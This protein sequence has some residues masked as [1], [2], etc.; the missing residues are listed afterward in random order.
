MS[1]Y[2]PSRV[3]WL[4]LCTALTACSQPAN[5]VL[6]SLE[7]PVAALTWCAVPP[8]APRPALPFAPAATCDADAASPGHALAFVLDAAT[9]ELRAADLTAGDPLDLD[10]FRPSFNGLPLGFAPLDA[11]AV[12]DEAV[13][14][15]SLEAWGQGGVVAALSLADPRTAR[16][17]L[18]LDEP[19][20]AVAVWEGAPGGAWVF[21]ALPHSHSVA[22]VPLAHLGDTGS[23][24]LDLLALPGAPSDVV[25]QPGND[26][27]ATL[28]VGFGDIASVASVDAVAWDAPRL[29]AVG[30]PCSDGLDNDGDGLTDAQDP[31][32]TGPSGRDEAA[33]P[34]DAA[35]ANG[36]DDDGDGLT[37]YPDDPGC[38]APDDPTEWSD[39]D[40]CHDG[41]DND[42]DGTTDAEDPECA[43]GPQEWPLPCADGADNDGDGLTD[44]DDPDCAASGSASELGV[45]ASC[46]NGLDDD[47]DGLTDGDDPDC[48]AGH[49][50]RR[51]Q[52]ANGA[53]DDGDGLTDASDPS[54]WTR[55]QER[56][57]AAAP[58]FDEQ[59]A[60]SPDGSVLYVTM[61]QRNEVAVVDVGSGVLVD[62]N[63][64]PDWLGSPLHA[65]EGR[66][67]VVLD[68]PPVALA[69]APSQADVAGEGSDATKAA[70]QAA[71]VALATGEVDLID[72]SVE[73]LGELHVLRASKDEAARA[74]Q[75]RVFVSGVEKKQGFSA[76]IDV[77]HLGSFEVD[78]DA[79]R[80]YGITLPAE[81]RH[82]PAESWT[83]WAG[84]V[85]P[86][87][88]RR[89]GRLVEVGRDDE[90]P[91]AV[92]ADPWADYCAVGVEPGDRVEVI[93]PRRIDC[94]DPATPDAAWHGDRFLFAIAAV[95]PDRLV[96]RPERFDDPCL[97]E[98]IAPSDGGLGI[99]VLTP[100]ERFDAQLLPEEPGE[101]CRP[102]PL[103]TPA[104]F[105]GELPYRIRAPRTTFLA[106]GSRSG[107]VHP[108]AN[109]DGQ[110]VR[111]AADAR[112]SGR[113]RQLE[114]TTPAPDNC[115]LALGAGLFADETPFENF[116]FSLVVYPGCEVVNALTG[117]S[118]YVPTWRD[119]QI[120]FDVQAGFVPRRLIP[121]PLVTRLQY[122]PLT[123]RVVLLEAAGGTLE[124]IDP[125]T[126]DVPTVIR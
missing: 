108:W 90:G 105:G 27:S 12:G 117:Q 18:E 15:G 70:A 113:I 56:E 67:G 98:G 51:P 46:H 35:C 32:C 6:P 34:R 3:A 106:I 101:R 94:T 23:G 24:E 49:S 84:G 123:D 59:L 44:G 38:A 89:T 1:R 71:F 96:L 85:L 126:L 10:A 124:L 29:L 82:V 61:R 88:E 11:A 91:F 4:A 54:C 52:C 22:R 16:A 120:R 58:R 43:V 97:E 107:F 81:G 122:D 66:R 112:A 65:F 110:C 28:W 100:Q 86:G 47:G 62:V 104:C 115:A 114:P 20:S 72:A 76:R 121:G 2:H 92:W 26:G 60:L 57:D 68:A 41:L 53:D 93:L 17:T 31:A 118:R 69:F 48:A 64:R 74:T 103:P 14:A 42:G 116:S 13:V 33:D 21:V 25:V 119:T 78:E 80:W 55:R 37:D 5:V 36:V 95:E 79:H 102:V 87:S 83:L 19:P 8:S 99:D 7:A 77:P 111:V 75:P 50:E 125:K 9:Q 73:G 40:G 30:P 45:G 39:A 63:A 109:R